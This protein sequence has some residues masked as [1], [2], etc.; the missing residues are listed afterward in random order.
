[1]FSL[2][3][4]R[5]HKLGKPHPGFL[6][7]AATLAS[8][9][10]PPA[11]YPIQDSLGHLIANGSLSDLQIEGVLFAAQKHQE[12]LPNKQRAGFFLAGQ[13]LCSSTLI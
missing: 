10:L 1:M 12:I 2:Y 6:T 3:Q 11:V 7:E 8:I 5:S 13:S 9:P 4:C